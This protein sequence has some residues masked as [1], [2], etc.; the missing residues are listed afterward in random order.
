[1][2]E[3]EWSFAFVT[4]I[5]SFPA[6]TPPGAAPTGISETILPLFASI[7]PTV[8]AAT[9]PDALTA[10]PPRVRST[11]SAAATATATTA[12]A[13]SSLRCRHRGSGQLLRD[14]LGELALAALE[15][16]RRRSF[17]WPE[18]LLEA[19]GEEL[20]DP[21]GL[22][23]VLQPVLTEVA[24]RDVGQ[25]IIPEQFAGRLRDEHLSA[26][27]GRADPGGSVHA[28]ADVALLADSRLAGMDAHT[29]A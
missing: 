19:G 9:S 5:A 12:T 17:Q 4:Q 28:E 1:M 10:P 6:A 15:R 8:L 27:T 20:V 23:Q 25:W 13:T 11:P 22:V 2:R 18:T 24:Q 14:R 26:P 21:L 7:T 3:T 16:R 29:Y